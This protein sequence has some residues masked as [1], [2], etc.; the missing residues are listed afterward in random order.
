MIRKILSLMLSALLLTLPLAACSQSTENAE[1]PASNSPATQSPENADDAAKAPEPDDPY[2]TRMAEN[3]NLPEYDFGGRDFIV[4][5]SA[6]EGFGI[7]IAVDELNG[8][9][10]NDAVFRRNLV[11]EERFNAKTVYEG[12]ADYGTCSTLVAK[13]VKAGDSDSYDLIQ[14]HVVSSS[15]NAMKSYYLNWYDIPN[16]DFSRS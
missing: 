9:G 12:G 5:G 2:A 3:D 11:V 13:A 4:L 6:Q 10:V 8:E 16:V 14:Y 1:T 7:Y 15:G